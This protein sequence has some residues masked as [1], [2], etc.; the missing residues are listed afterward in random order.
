[1]ILDSNSA[2]ALLAQAAPGRSIAA[3]SELVFFAI[4]GVIVACVIGGV[5]VLQYRDKK[6]REKREDADHQVQREAFLKREEVQRRDIE[7]NIA[8]GNESLRKLRLEIELM[9][10]QKRRMQGGPPPIVGPDADDESTP[11]TPTHD[12][13]N[14]LMAQKMER[15]LKLLDVQVELARRDQA[16][17]SDQLDYHDTMMEKAKLEIE[18][19]KL[20]IQEQRKR[21]DEGFGG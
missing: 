3:Q 8:L 9:E 18:S 19:L 2:S 1:M 20:H 7:Q 4:F 13:L 14:R 15:E 12:D 21:L 10:L 5:L 11:S 6:R 16:M 17:R